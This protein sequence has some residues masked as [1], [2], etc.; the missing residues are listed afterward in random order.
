[1]KTSD[2]QQKI[3]APAEPDREPAGDR[4]DDRICREITRDDPFAI[5]HRR[6]QSAGDVTQRHVRDRRV[7][8]FHEGRNDNGERDEPRIDGARNRRCRYASERQPMTALIIL[9]AS[10]LAAGA[11][12]GISSCKKLPGVRPGRL[13]L[14]I[15]RGRDGKADEKRQLVGIV[16]H[17]IDPHRQ[18]LH[19]FHEVAGRVLRRQQGQRRAG[20]HREAGDASLERLLA[21]VHVDFQIRRAGRCADREVAFP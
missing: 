1:M 6:R 4:Q 17:Q 3:I 13:A 18:P 20:A 14:Q 11:G 16:I 12:C 21:A 5:G 2:R 10:A 8:H 9:P 7:Q 19:D 15:D